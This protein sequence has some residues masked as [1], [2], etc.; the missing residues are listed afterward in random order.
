[1]QQSDYRT[2]NVE[3]PLTL[4][5]IFLVVTVNDA[6]PGA[7]ATVTEMLA[8]LEDLVKTVGFREPTVRLSCTVGIGARV[9]SEVCGLKT[10]FELHPFREI[11]GEKHTAVSTPGDLLFHIRAD[12]EDLAYEFE[13]LLLKQ[14]GDAVTPVDEVVGFR[15]FDSRDLLGFVDGTANPI[16]ADLPAAALVGGEDPDFT[17]G[18][19]LVVQKYLH[20]LADWQALSTEAQEAIIGRTKPDNIELDDAAA[21]AQKSHKTLATIT[22]HEGE[23]DIVR[24]N[25]PFARPAA[26][27]FGTYFIGYARHLWVIE[28]MLERMFIGDPPGMHDRILDFSTAVTGSTYFVPTPAFLAGLSD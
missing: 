3:G 28:K 23:H 19:Y 24:D 9:W 21:D 5:A 8:G 10:P 22:D 17:G 7:M 14:L 1:M 11:R 20:P 18:S 2:Q 26:G 16:G 25:M 4:R 13:R 12:R 6:Q 27:E 15:Y